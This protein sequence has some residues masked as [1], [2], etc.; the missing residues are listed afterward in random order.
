MTRVSPNSIF[1]PV[2][3]ATS[4][5]ASTVAC[6]RVA[7]DKA[8]AIASSRAAARSSEPSSLAMAVEE[9]RSALPSATIIAP[10]TRSPVRLRMV[11]PQP[12]V[13]V[14]LLALIH[15]GS[16][17][18]ASRQ[19]AALI[20][21]IDPSGRSRALCSSFES[22]AEPLRPEA[23]GA[24]DRGPGVY[25]G[26]AFAPASIDPRREQFARLRI[27]DLAFDG[28]T[29]DEPAQLRIDGTAWRRRQRS[30]PGSEHVEDRIRG[31]RIGDREPDTHDAGT[32]LI[33]E[34]E[35]CTEL[36]ADRVL[37]HAHQ[38]KQVILGNRGERI[39]AA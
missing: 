1:S 36:V 14:T 28:R 9:A 38:P 33:D 32:R 21:F 17:A 3:C 10:R 34:A 25:W 39:P 26:R 23:D 30:T 13:R 16:S 24:I 7:L 19:V 31:A 8:P 29:L 18:P 12:Y 22:P 37:E 20:P 6:N 2:G 4:Q 27:A 15:H 35:P 11:P 5:L